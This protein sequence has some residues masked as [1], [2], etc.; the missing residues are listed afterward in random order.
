MSHY[1][2]FPL[3]AQIALVILVASIFASSVVLGM[4]MAR[5]CY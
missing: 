1:D 2:D 5:V 3:W 4:I